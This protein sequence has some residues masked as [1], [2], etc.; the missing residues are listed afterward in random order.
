MFGVLASN[1]VA[2]REKL[3]TFAWV[4][5]N[6]SEMSHEL[7]LGVEVRRSCRAGANNQVQNVAVV[8]LM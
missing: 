3:K 1:I 7:A 6:Q 8:C 2:G 4:D 5:E